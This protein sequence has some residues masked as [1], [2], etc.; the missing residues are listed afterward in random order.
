M[1]LVLDSIKSTVRFQKTISEAWLKVRRASEAD[2]KAKRED[3]NLTLV[4]CFFSP[5]AIESV[6]D[7]ENHKVSGTPSRFLLEF[8][9]SDLTLDV[10]LWSGGGS[11][12]ALHPPLHQRQPESA[13]NR[14][15]AEGQSEGRPDAGGAAP[16]DLQG[17]FSGQSTII[18]WL[19]VPTL[20]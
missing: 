10:W 3:L 11:T 7:V 19:C 16:Q 5:K 12:A 1:A 17:L 13:R 18:Q 15:A 9:R 6:D 8:T 4:V 2:R 20:V 14:E